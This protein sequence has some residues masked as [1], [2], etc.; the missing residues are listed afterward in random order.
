MCVNKNVRK[1]TRPN[2][3]TV[4]RSARRGFDRISSSD[5]YGARKCTRWKDGYCPLPC[6]I[7]STDRLS[8]DKSLRG[9]S[10]QPAKPLSCLTLAR[11]LRSDRL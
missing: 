3:S 7:S 5:V 10:P 8:C 9:R 6:R 2:V 4:R 11:K 1:G